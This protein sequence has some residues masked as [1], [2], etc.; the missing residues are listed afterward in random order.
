MDGGSGRDAGGQ[1][2]PPA[3][4]WEK[5][6][7]ETQVGTIREWLFTPRPRFASFEDLNAWLAEQCLKIAAELPLSKDLADVDVS[8]SPVNAE[9][10]RDLHGGSARMPGA[11]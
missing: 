11:S 9:L 8:A 5:G 2:R 6:Q 7:V 10:I 1:Q 4:G 3:A